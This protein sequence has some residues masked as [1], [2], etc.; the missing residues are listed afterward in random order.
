[1]AMIH[2]GRH[3]HLAKN[4]ESGDRQNIILWYRSSKWRDENKYEDMFDPDRPKQTECPRWCWHQK[5]P[6]VVEKE[7]I[8]KVK[9]ENL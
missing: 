8:K 7:N 9:N 1:M 5:I 6:S 2:L 4:I 3:K